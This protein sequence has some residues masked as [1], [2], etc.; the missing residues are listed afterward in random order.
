MVRSSQFK[1]TELTHLEASLK[2]C[3]KPDLL[4]Q[5]QQQYPL[6]IGPHFRPKQDQDPGRIRYQPFFDYMYGSSKQAVKKA[7]ATGTMVAILVKAKNSRHSCQPSTSQ[8]SI[9]LQ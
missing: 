1:F 3:K 9:G 4:S 2:C 5:M 7:A 8:A 6:K